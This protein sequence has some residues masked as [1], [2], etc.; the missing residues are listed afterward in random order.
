[1]KK[2]LEGSFFI[3]TDDRFDIPHF[4]AK[5]DTLIIFPFRKDGNRFFLYL[6]IQMCIRSIEY[7]CLIS[8]CYADVNMNKSEG[9]EWK[10]HWSALQ[11]TPINSGK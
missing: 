11:L 9:L 8:M 10:N 1:M 3:S 4:L 7:Y 5:P 6:G 2:D